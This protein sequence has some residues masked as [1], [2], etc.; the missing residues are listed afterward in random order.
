M[1]I[2]EIK[3]ESFVLMTAAADTSAAFIGPFVNHVIQDRRVYKMLVQEIRS[4]QLAG[5]L[6]SPVATFN[7]TNEM[8][9]FI[10]CVKE[11]LRFSPPTPFILP[12]LVSRGGMEV[13]GIWVPEGTEIGGNP[14]VIHRDS[15]KFGADAD[16]FRPERWLENEKAAKEMDKYIFS[17]GYGTRTCLGKNIAQMI[18]QKLCLHVSPRL[19]SAGFDNIYE[20]M[21]CS[22]FE[23]SASSQSIL[24]SHGAPRIWAS[25]YIGTSGSPLAR[26]CTSQNRKLQ[27]SGSLGHYEVRIGTELRG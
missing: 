9:Y 1:S 13:N 20:K 26:S 12:R 2:D 19:Q 11:T 10:A 5:K 24:R 15:A 14:Y 25:C 22:C 21:Y 17:W 7:E 27:C 4:F 3:T 18:T 6:S 16:L 23:C 8:P